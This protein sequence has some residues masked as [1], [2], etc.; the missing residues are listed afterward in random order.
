MRTQRKK[1]SNLI[2][3]IRYTDPKT[4]RKRYAKRKDLRYKT[5]VTKI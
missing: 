4:K 3:N 1:K 5:I 2:H